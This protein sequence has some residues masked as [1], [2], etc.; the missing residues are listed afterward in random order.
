M[1][2][3]RLLTASI[4]D[5]ST[6]FEKVTSIFLQKLVLLVPDKFTQLIKFFKF[7]NHSEDISFFI[8]LEKFS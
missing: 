6:I 8:I 3:G 2:H 5:K 4:R 1:N 7:L